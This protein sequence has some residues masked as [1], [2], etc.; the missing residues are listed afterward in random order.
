MVF[1]AFSAQIFCYRAGPK[2][3]RLPPRAEGLFLTA[4]WSFQVIPPA[5]GGA[6][7]AISGCEYPARSIKRLEYA[8]D[9]QKGV[10]YRSLC[11][12]VGSRA[13][14][15]EWAAVSVLFNTDAETRMVSGLALQLRR[16]QRPSGWISPSENA[17][18]SPHLSKA[19][20][21]PCRLRARKTNQRQIASQL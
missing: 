17:Q 6:R 13:R 16:K 15:A 20:A 8:T 10:P 21:S 3:L 5:L 2:P 4:L 7:E 9:T 18:K 11:E 19:N 12:S 14:M 1:V